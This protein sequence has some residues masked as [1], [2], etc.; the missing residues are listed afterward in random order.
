MVA[1]T[2]LDWR[3]LD[4]F[5]LVVGRGIA[6]IE[7][8]SS[9]QAHKWLK[10]NGYALTLLDF[11]E[12]ISPV[13]EKL[14]RQLKWVEKF[15][16]ELTGDSRNLAALRDG[17]HFEVPNT[18]GIVLNIRNFDQAIQAEPKWSS[19]FLSIVA[20]YSLRHLA[21]G[22][23]FFGLVEVQNSESPEVEHV[24]EALSVPFP[25]PLV[26]GAAS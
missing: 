24:F 8:A 1:F 13:V 3:R 21:C 19:A 10:A 23:R 18:G 9:T 22:R 16:Y 17:F 15:G 5:A 14:G 12:G 20:E 25:F 7:I 11:R 6:S 4:V 2:D 26:S